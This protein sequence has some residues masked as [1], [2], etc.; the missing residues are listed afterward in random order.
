M[1]DRGLVCGAFDVI[2]PGYIRLFI[3]AKKNCKEL[4]IAL[5]DDPTVDRPKKIKPIQSLEDRKLIL[6][7]IKY[8]DKIYCY[9]TESSLYELLQTD[10]YDVRIL[11]TDYID[12]NYT[13]KDLGKPVYYHTR[14]HGYSTTKFKS[15]IKN[16]TKIS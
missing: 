7:S 10:I 4:I 8:V 2:H 5:Q 9:T 16:K 1:W 15:D 14:N 12:K 13:G 3:D 11:G 6:E